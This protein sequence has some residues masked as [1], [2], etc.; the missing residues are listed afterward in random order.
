MRNHLPSAFRIASTLRWHVVLGGAWACLVCCQMVLAEDQPDVEVDLWRTSGQKSSVEL[1][2]IETGH[3][4]I[5]TDEEVQK[6]TA[7]EVWQVALDRP[8]RRPPRP[9]YWLYLTSGDRWGVSSIKLANEELEFR[10]PGDDQWRKLEIGSVTGIQPVRPGTTWRTDESE[11]LQIIGRREKS[12]QVILRNGDHQTGDLSAFDD[13]GLTLTGSLGT[14]SLEWAGVSGLLLN[15]DLAETPAQP[16]E[17]WTIL[18]HNQSW[19]TVTAIHPPVEG[20]CQ[21]TTVHNVEWSVPLDEISWAAP[22]GPGVVP[23]SRVPI[24][25]QTHQPQLGETFAVAI[26]R[27]VRGL[28][29]R[30]N[31]ANSS[32]D[33]SNSRFPAVCPLGLGLTSGMAVQWKLDGNYRRFLGGL[34]LDSTAC[35]A[36]H[37]VVKLSVNN[38]PP[39]TVT[40]RAG[41]PV[42]WLAPLE[43]TGAQTLSIETEPGENA[44]VCDW[45]NLIH[46]VLVR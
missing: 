39:Q 29:L 43:L 25:S 9:V 1:L 46:P 30:L 18:L 41:D 19:L 20:L 7:S 17:G 21:L 11:W 33:P 32:S 3:L 10:I 2:A 31:T 22:W 5:K 40:L 35:P 26:N 27:N 45:I 34:C 28:T 12:D 42:T 38:Q 13:T 16:P 44:D 36:G 14:K 8:S 37:A 15:P 4:S 24:A 6:L 23:L